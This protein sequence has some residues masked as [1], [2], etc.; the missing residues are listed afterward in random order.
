MIELVKHY[1]TLAVVMASEQFVPG[2]TGQCMNPQD[3]Y[4]AAKHF[5]ELSPAD[6]GRSHQRPDL[7]FSP[8][9]APVG[10]GGH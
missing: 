6:Q 10:A 9:L 4:R 8:G 1:D 3:A 2:G 7:S 5:V